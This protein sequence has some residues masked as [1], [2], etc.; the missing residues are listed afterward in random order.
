MHMFQQANSPSLILDQR[1]FSEEYVPDRLT[2]REAQVRAIVQCLTPA[3][4][5]H[6]PVHLWLCGRPGTGKTAAA[7]HVLGRFAEKANLQ[8]LVVNC[9]EKD[10]FFEIVDDIVLRLRILRAEEHRTSTKLD[11]LRRYLADRPLIIVLDEIDRMGPAERSTTLY[12]LGGMGNVG[13]ICITNRQGSLFEL[14]ERV[15][16]RLSPHLV[17]FPAYSLQELAH[18][19]ECRAEAGLAPA[20]WPAP[21]LRRIAGMADGDARAAIQALRRAAELTEEGEAV[22]SVDVLAEQHALASEAR[23]AYVLGSLA[24][25]HRALYGI[26]RQRGQVLSNDLWQEYLHQCSESGRKPLAARTF[27]NYAN[28]LVHKGLLVCEQ[29][30]VKG[31]VRL[32]KVAG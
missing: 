23:S 18:I 1:Q 10:T 2:G 24:E 4:S 5:K 20:A 11:R 22:V 26:V 8:S 3:L 19:L 32:F 9:W 17:F 29:A 25:D 30:R 28:T 6:K 12:N 21:V 16:S 14:E 31:K 15:R 27:S 7:L 13:L